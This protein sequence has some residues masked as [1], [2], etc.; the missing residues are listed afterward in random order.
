M[1][2][3]PYGYRIENGTAVIDDIAADKLRKLYENYLSGM[4][5]KKAAAGAGID[6][7]HGTVKRLLTN[8]HYIGDNFYPAIIDDEIF[9]KAQME[10]TARAAALGRTNKATKQTI[11]KAPTIFSIKDIFEP[12]GKSDPAIRAEFIYSLIESEEK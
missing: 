9:N 11:P 3:T 10:L 6:T 1:G 2:H 12:Y 7:Y 5:L 4:S 8:R